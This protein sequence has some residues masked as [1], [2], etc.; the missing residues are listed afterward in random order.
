MLENLADANT[1]TASIDFAFMASITSM[2]SSL[3]LAVNSTI[4]IPRSRAA[5]SSASGRRSWS[6]SARIPIRFEFGTAS[7]SNSRR[8][9][10]SSKAKIDTPV[11]F[12]SGWAIEPTSPL[13]TR[14]SA[15]A[16]IGMLRVACFTAC[17]TGVANAK[18]TSGRAR[19]NSL[20]TV[21]K[22]VGPKPRRST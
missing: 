18:T 12:P 4:S 14:S 20:A 17:A 1:L 15:I 13:V 8:L 22:A 3:D 16:T 6:G 19:T 5:R 2:I 9:R 7:C 11:T 21:S 10:S